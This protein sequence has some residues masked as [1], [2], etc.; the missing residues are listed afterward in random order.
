[1]NRINSIKMSDST[2]IKPLRIA[3]ISPSI[4]EELKSKILPESQV[5]VHCSFTGSKDFDYIRIWESTYLMDCH[6]N[7]KSE[8]VHHENIV[9][10]PNWMHVE[11]NKTIRFTLIFTGLPASCVL[12]DLVEIIGES[13]GFYVGEI[14]RNET[15]VY[16]VVMT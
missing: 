14:A 2:V 9:L 12:F 8:L 6:S 1:M 10:Y 13:G 4:K 3:H 15:D 16:S 5:I 11:P 7:H